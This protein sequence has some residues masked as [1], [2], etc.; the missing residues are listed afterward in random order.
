[1]IL[2]GLGANLPHP[3][4]GPPRDTLEAAL[5]ALQA[6]GVGLAGCSPWYRTPPWPP[7]DMPWYV[8]GVAALDTGLE[9]GPLMAL[10]HR[11]ERA[12]GRIR[13][14]RNE[15]R[16]LDLDLLAYGELVSAPGAQPALPH[17]RLAERGFVLLP[18][19]ALAPGWRHPVSGLTVE[20]MIGRLPE[21]ERR[22]ERLDDPEA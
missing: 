10:L 13:E 11:T 5:R 20:A 17:P 14:R 2:L 4:H 6:A 3:R 8:N 7:S 18:L 12:F 9:P 1:M 15:A 19:A 21:A 16:V 22:A